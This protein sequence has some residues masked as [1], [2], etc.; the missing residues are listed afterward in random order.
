MLYTFQAA[1]KEEDFSAAARLRDKILEL[2]R[3]DPVKALKAQLE[4]AID[5]Q[6][7]KVMHSQGSSRL[8]LVSRSCAVLCKML[9]WLQLQVTNAEAVWLLSQQPEQLFLQQEAARCRDEL[10]KLVPEPKP[11]TP[12]APPPPTSSDVVTNGVRVEVKRYCA[13][14]TVKQVGPYHG[15]C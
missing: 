12:L 4:Q 3:K 14:L 8:K 1:V 9:A 5:E 6:D 7:F 2:E 15:A 10:K 13:D 11:R